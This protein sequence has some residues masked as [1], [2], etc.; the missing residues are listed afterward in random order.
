M[1]RLLLAA[2][3]IVAAPAASAAYIVGAE[4]VLS[5]LSLRGQRAVRPWVWAGPALGFLAAFLVYPAL[6]TLVLSVRDG[7]GRQWIG[8]ANYRVVLTDP[9]TRTAVWNNLLWLAGFTGVT[10]GL[11]LAVAA[12]ADRARYEAAA[13]A[14]VF[15]P[16]ALSFTAAGVIWKFIYEFRPTGAP[17]IGVLN[18][19][20]AAT[21]PHF[22]PRA[23]LVAPP[24]N[25]LF[26]IAAGVWIWT[27]FCT[28]VLSAALK[29]VPADL[30]DAARVDGA[31]EARVFWSVVLPTIAPTVAIVAATMVI[32]SLKVFDVV[33]VMTNGNFGTEVIANRM[34]KEMFTFQ[35]FGRAGALA[36]LLL[37]ATAP[38]MLATVRRLRAEEAAR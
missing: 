36:V 11:G 10:V 18:A 20:L 4:A 17:Q 9:D 7:G 27:G 33:Y 16:M 23:W 26:L 22:Q 37:M 3:V 6:S 31:G 34:Y 2:L 38:F 14:I 30:T 1:N 19:V 21:V 25:T 24:A 29:G 5:R 28:V 13:R 35:H 15:L 32:T 12:L 8:L